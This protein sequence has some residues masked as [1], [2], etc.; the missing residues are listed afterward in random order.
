[1]HRSHLWSPPHI[2]GLRVAA[3]EL[4]VFRRAYLAHGLHLVRLYA[5]W[6]SIA[7][8]RDHARLYLLF[9]PDHSEF[10]LPGSGSSGGGEGEGSCSAALFCFQRSG[11]ASSLWEK[12]PVDRS[13]EHTSELQS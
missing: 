1:M 11:P 4:V 7:R 8:H 3:A 5:P 12:H 2:R 10:S 13:E 6:L 9:Q